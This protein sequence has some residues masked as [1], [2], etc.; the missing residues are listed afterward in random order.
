M[1]VA[2]AGWNLHLPV[3][4]SSTAVIIGVGLV[5]EV[6]LL[7]VDTLKDKHCLQGLEPGCLTCP[8][9]DG[10]FCLCVHSSQRVGYLCLH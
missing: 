1:Y 2:Q 7:C 4:A 6:L 10:P 9:I 3:S 5:L 8:I